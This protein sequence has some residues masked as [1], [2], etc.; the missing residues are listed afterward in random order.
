MG[1]N[2]SRYDKFD[3]DKSPQPKKRKSFFFKRKL[4]IFPSPKSQEPNSLEELH[5]TQKNSTATTA[6]KNSIASPSTSTRSSNNKIKNPSVPSRQ[7]A[8]NLSLE[9]KIDDVKLPDLKTRAQHQRQR[10]EKTR[11]ILKHQRENLEDQIE[12][13]EGRRQRA[14]ARLNSS[15][16]I[17]IAG[18]VVILFIFSFLGTENFRAYGLEIIFILIS[19]VFGYDRFGRRF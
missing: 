8:A 7:S 2:K 9:Q 12:D 18:T 6:T 1:K 17:L 15:L 10:F 16:L 5:S 4:E 11:R 3:L 19:I 14:N 13:L